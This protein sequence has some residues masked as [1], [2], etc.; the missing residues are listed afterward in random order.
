MRSYDQSNSDSRTRNN[1]DAGQPEWEFEDRV[2]RNTGSG[3]RVNPIQELQM[4]GRRNN[5]ND[6]DEDE[7]PFNFQA[8]LRKTRH[9][10]SSMKRTPVY[11]SYGSSPL[12]GTEHRKRDQD[13]NVVYKSG[14]SRMES[15]EWSPNEMVR[16]SEKYG[17]E[18]A[19]GGDRSTSA[20]R[21]NAIGARTSESITTEIAPGIVVE[22]YVAEL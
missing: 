14:G 10:R 2:N 13:S 18:G 6:G 19:W 3:N 11:D 17:K 22:G 21:R 20:D 15:P 1:I 12:P 8:M 9:Q 7:P 16:M 4:I 5:N